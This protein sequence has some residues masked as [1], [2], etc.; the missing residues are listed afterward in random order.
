VVD[1]KGLKPTYGSK[2]HKVERLISN[3]V[4]AIGIGNE[5]GKE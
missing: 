4:D 5:C 1:L 2:D 3:N